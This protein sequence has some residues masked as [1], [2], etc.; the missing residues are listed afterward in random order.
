M[1]FQTLENSQSVLGIILKY[2]EN[3]RFSYIASF[4]TLILPHRLEAADSGCMFTSP[5]SMYF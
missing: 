4:I 5:F 2:F 1:M 3:M